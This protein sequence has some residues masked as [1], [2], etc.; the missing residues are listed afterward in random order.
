MVS[1]KLFPAVAGL[2]PGRKRRGRLEQRLDGVLLLASAPPMRGAGS[3]CVSSPRA[4]TCPS[5]TALLCLP[6]HATFAVLQQATSKRLAILPLLPLSSR[7]S[8]LQRDGAE[9]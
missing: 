3:P 2:V 8:L 7:R 4:R 9:S 1:R 5:T 6:Q